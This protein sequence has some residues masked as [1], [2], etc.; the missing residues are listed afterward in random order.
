MQQSHIAYCEGLLLGTI[1]ALGSHPVSRNPSVELLRILKN[2][3]DLGCPQPPK[4][5][6]E[7]N[8]LRGQKTALRAFR[9]CETFTAAV[10][11]LSVILWKVGATSILDR[12]LDLALLNEDTG[13]VLIGR[14]L[15]DQILDERIARFDP[16][17]LAASILADIDADS[18][19]SECQSFEELHEICD[20]N[21]LGDTE[22]FIDYMQTGFYTEGD[23]S[24]AFQRAITVLNRAH[25]LVNL[26]LSSRLPA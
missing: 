7:W 22:L 16:K 14:L 13:E 6:Q 9:D 21:T 12:F 15:P 3:E 1:S 10:D 19:L 5:S 17:L 23:G 8:F 18:A 2:S 24:R 20:A 4:G 11:R 26:E 25:E